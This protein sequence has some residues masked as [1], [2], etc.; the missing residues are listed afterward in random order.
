MRKVIVFKNEGNLSNTTYNKK[1]NS[2]GRI[3]T[4][5]AAIANIEQVIASGEYNAEGD[6]ED[7]QE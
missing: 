6:N 3:S 5:N 2:T 4:I 7:G 1:Q